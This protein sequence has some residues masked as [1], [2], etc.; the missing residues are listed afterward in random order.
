M[1]TRF[2]G[3]FTDDDLIGMLQETYIKKLDLISSFIG[4]LIDL[5]WGEPETSPVQ[6]VVTKYV[7][8]MNK[9]YGR[10]RLQR[11][12]ASDF[13]TLPRDIALFKANGLD[14]FSAYQKLEMGSVKWHMLDNVAADIIRQGDLHLC[15]ACL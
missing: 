2:N 13:A 9:V 12:T 1:E 14:V 7:D 8:V 4:G 3:V 5:I 6:T 15:H 11:C 10:N